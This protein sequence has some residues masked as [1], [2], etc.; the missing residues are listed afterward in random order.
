MYIWLENICFFNTSINIEENVFIFLFSNSLKWWFFKN[1]TIPIADI[2]KN[3][4]L[5]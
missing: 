5:S 3:Y 2:Y 1:E 4:K